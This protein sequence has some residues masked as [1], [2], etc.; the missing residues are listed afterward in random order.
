MC[1]TGECG[2]VRS[3]LWFDSLCFLYSQSLLTGLG[4]VMA[5]EERSLTGTWDVNTLKRWKWKSA[6]YPSKGRWN[7]MAGVLFVVNG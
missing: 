7:K 2:A 1:H 6:Q 4:P 3:K 5:V